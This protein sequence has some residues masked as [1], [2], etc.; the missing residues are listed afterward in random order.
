LAGVSVGSVAS[1]VASS[2]ISP[3]LGRVGS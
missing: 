1:L 2:L 3:A